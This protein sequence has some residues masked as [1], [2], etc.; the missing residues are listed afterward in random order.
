MSDPA[1]DA[2]DHLA[3]LE[4]RV[5]RTALAAGRARQALNGCLGGV[6][7]TNRVN[8]WLAAVQ[9]GNVAVDEWMA[10]MHAHAAAAE[11]EGRA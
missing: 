1:D 6:E 2:R 11:A 4:E 5:L 8:A 10:A 9:A 3:D 7:L